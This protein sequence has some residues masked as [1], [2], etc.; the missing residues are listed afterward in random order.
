MWK[1]CKIYCVSITIYKKKKYKRKKKN[2]NYYSYRASGGT[3]ATVRNY[4]KIKKTK[5]I[6]S[7]KKV[8][9]VY[10]RYSGIAA[11]YIVN[12]NRNR[13]NEILRWD[14]ILLRIKHRFECLT[15]YPRGK[16]SEK[17]NTRGE[18]CGSQHLNFY[19]C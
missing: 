19:V 2:Y 1:Y 11:F 3:V 17:K 14:G 12:R 16:F 10:K 18:R 5:Q 6:N 7:K 8:W 9:T 15:Q 4:L 13:Y